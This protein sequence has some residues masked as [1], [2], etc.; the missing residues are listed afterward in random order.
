MALVR[1]LVDGYSLLH[2]WP[3]LAPGAER[4]SARAREEL[5]H[6]LTRYHDATGEPITIIFDGVGSLRGLPENGSGGAVEVLFSRAG[7][8]A[9][10][11]IERA[12]HRFLAHGEVLVV[13]DDLAER[14]TVSGFGGSVASCAN[15]VRMV[16]NALTELQDELRSHNRKERN[17]F[18]RPPNA[19]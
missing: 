12:A 2:N 6:V 7:Q 18:K 11:L 19:T 8:T 15:F 16:E 3:D 5:V 10:Q 1:I 17:Q 14:D 4:H 9:D 13:T